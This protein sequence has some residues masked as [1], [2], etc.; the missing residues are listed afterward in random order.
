VFIP[1][2]ITGSGPIRA[3]PHATVNVAG[4]APD[5]DEG[6]G[7]MPARPEREHDGLGRVELVYQPP[8]D[9]LALASSSQKNVRVP[10]QMR[11]C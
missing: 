8:G 7:P 6:E 10:T 3:T 4:H 9:G 5:G 1:V 2:R 11:I